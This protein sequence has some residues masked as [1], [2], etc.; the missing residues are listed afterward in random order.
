MTQCAI[1]E[2]W[3]SG[4]GSNPNPCHGTSWPQLRH[5]LQECGAREE[6]FQTRQGAQSSPSHAVQFH[7]ITIVDNE[8]SDYNH[9]QSGSISI[10]QDEWCWQTGMNRENSGDPT[11]PLSIPQ[12]IRQL[13]HKSIENR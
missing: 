12:K 11:E 6:V 4:C 5:W 10:I 2:K 1:E 13:S 9:S 8:R 3:V 7:L